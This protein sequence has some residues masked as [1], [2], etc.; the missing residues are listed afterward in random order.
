MR[1]A[2]PSTQ[3]WSTLIQVHHRTTQL[4]KAI[5]GLDKR[6]LASKYLHFHVPHLFYI[7]DSRAVEA[8]S[9]IR[10][11]VGR[12]GG[13]ALKADSEYEKFA[14]KCLS[15]QLFIE[16]QYGIRMKPRDL[17]NLLLQICEHKIDESHS[18]NASL[19]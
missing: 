9:R 19:E 4:F 18:R 3:S 12:S 2:S 16:D 6:S 5:S 14:G 8:I 1:Y 15:L 10:G 7:Y 13:A 11:L 17:D